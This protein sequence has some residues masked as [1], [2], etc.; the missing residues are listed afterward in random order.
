MIASS[1]NAKCQPA[2]DSVKAAVNQLFTAMK[3][4]DGALL[5][6]CFADSALLQTITRNKEGEMSVKYESIQNFATS[7][8]SAPKSC[9]RRTH[10]F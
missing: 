8:N 2:E 10:P 6:Y 7:I 4:S 5:L 3:T 9:I 1:F